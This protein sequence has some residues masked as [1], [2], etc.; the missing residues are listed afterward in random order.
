M[1]W[2]VGIIIAVLI[3]WLVLMYNGLVRLKNMVENG[4]SQIDVQLQRRFDL[5]P[6]LVET[7]K[8]YAAHEKELFENIAKAKQS[9]INAQGVAQKGEASGELSNAL[10]S[11]FALSEAYPELKANQNFLELQQELKGT[12]DK[13]SFA[14]QF[15]ND[16]VTRLNQQIDMFPTNIVASIFNFT[17]REYF[18]IDTPEARGPVKV[19]F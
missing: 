10:K 9:L 13:I 17:K 14:R 12:E 7:V 2:I 4:W 5:I 11:I 8:G 16:S 6:N 1:G 3:V 15:Y 19:Q 18:E